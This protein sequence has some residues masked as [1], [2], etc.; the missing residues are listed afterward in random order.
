V[1][2]LG[3]RPDLERRGGWPIK[4]YMCE[5]INRRCYTASH[6]V[7]YGNKVKQFDIFCRAECKSESPVPLSQE[8]AS[9]EAFFQ[10]APK[11]ALLAAAQTCIQ[12]PS[13]P[14]LLPLRR[15]RRLVR[16]LNFVRDLLLARAGQR[17]RHCGR[18]SR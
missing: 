16:R 7:D 14:A 5:M 9:S 15:Q 11:T 17:S 8:E 3:L 13:G 1:P 10:L 4:I 2:S 12:V 6:Y 18:S